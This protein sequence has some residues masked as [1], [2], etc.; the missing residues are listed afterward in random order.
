M[1]RLTEFLESLRHHQLVRGQFRAILHVVIGRTITLND[2]TVVSSGV[3][4][5]ELAKLLQTIRWDKELVR[6]LGLNPDDLP[7]RDRQRF[8]YIAISTAKVMSL[9]ARNLGD[10]FARLVVPIG[11]LIGPAPG[12]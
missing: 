6:E 12:N 10:Q 9:D 2:G 5:R 8:W 1:E 3:T 4:W 11:Y 7:P